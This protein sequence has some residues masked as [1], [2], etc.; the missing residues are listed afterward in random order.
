M[1][2]NSSDFFTGLRISSPCTQKMAAGVRAAAETRETAARGYPEVRHLFSCASVCPL[3]LREK[4]MG[5]TLSVKWWR[6][7]YPCIFGITTES[8]TERKAVKFSSGPLKMQRCF[9]PTT[10]MVSSEEKRSLLS[11]ALRNL[12]LLS[13]FLF[14]PPFKKE[15]RD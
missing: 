4:K 2:T 15:K 9:Y 13:V 1:I 8:E 10:A 3:A 11:W 6:S 5:I 7:E 12:V 14:S